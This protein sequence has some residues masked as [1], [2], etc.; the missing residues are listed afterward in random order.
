MSVIDVIGV[1]RNDQVKCSPFCVT[2]NK[3]PKNDSRVTILIDDI[4]T[5]IYMIHEKS[6]NTLFPMEFLNSDTP[7]K[8]ESITWKQKTLDMIITVPP[9]ELLVPDGKILGKFFKENKISKE[10]NTIKFK[11]DE[12]V[13][14]ANFFLWNATEKIIIVDIGT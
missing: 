14:E 9:Y 12:E 2:F 5:G 1:I 6:G 10:I 4:D 11:T 8:K 3:K 7:T 13:L